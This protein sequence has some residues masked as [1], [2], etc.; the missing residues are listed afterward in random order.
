M[1]KII[2]QQIALDKSLG[3]ELVITDTEAFIAHNFKMTQARRPNLW[4]RIKAFFTGKRLTYMV[5]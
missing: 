5:L 3:Q 2:E 4:Q 1:N